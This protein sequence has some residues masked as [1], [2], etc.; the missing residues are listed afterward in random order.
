MKWR[1]LH[2]KQVRYL[3]INQ[4]KLANY[5][6]IIEILNPGRSLSTGSISPSAR[7]SLA[8]DRPEKCKITWPKKTFHQ[9]VVTGVDGF[10]PFLTINTV[11]MSQNKAFLSMTSYKSWG[12]LFEKNFRGWHFNIKLLYGYGTYAAWCLREFGTAAISMQ[13]V[14]ILYATIKQY[15]PATLIRSLG[16]YPLSLHSNAST[17]LHI[18]CFSNSIYSSS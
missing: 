6:K 7:L 14:I 5:R 18:L 15:F 8:R 1:C 3:Q 4:I 10:W 12:S 2:W 13:T 11:I 9:C 17:S 16:P